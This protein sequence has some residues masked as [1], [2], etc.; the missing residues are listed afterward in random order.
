[1]ERTTL[2]TKEVADYLGISTG[3]VYTLVRERKIPSVKLGRR[4]LFKID[5]VDRWLAQQESA[6][7]EAGEQIG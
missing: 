6:A 3:L 1:M 5:S 4:I 7:L 2:T